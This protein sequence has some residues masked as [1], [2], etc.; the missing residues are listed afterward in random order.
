[1][2]AEIKAIEK[3]QTWELVEFPIGAK[4]IGVKWIYKTKLNEFGEIDKHKARLVAKGYSQEHRVDYTE[5]FSPV[6]RM[7]TVRIVIP[8]AAQRG[9]TLF[10]LD[11][12]YAFLYGT[13]S[14]NVYVD[15]LKG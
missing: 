5:V 10:Q 1:M 8:L 11:V 15:Q 9:W 13:L 2:E 7:D 4:K 14:E 12:K 6:A 3:N